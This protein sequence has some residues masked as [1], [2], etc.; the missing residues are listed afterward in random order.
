MA[1]SPLGSFSVSEW[2]QGFT[3]N[4]SMPRRTA[5]EPPP[6]KAT[7]SQASS[8]DGAQSQRL[9]SF[10][11]AFVFAATWFISTAMAAPLP[12]LL[13]AGGATLATAVLVSALIGPAQVGAR[14]LEFGLL[15]RIHPLLSARMAAALHAAGAIAFGVAEAPA[16]TLLGVLHGAGNGILPIAKGTLPL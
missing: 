11:L 6:A 9:S 13:Q 10:A 4:L 3:N 1:S 15:R 2:L 12:R 16:A 7:S 5:I 8:D 14:I